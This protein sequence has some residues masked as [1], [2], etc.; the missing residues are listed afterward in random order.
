MTKLPSDDQK[1]QAFLRQ[2]RPVPPPATIDLEEQ[3]MQAIAFN[4]NTTVN[5]QTNLVCVKPQKL[6]LVRQLWLIPSTIAACLLITSS[7]H[8]FFTAPEL[9]NASLESFLETNW[10]DVTGETAANPARNNLLNDWILET[11]PVN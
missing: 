6:N 1:L 7:S 11:K 3:L 5:K 2:H 9:A 10:N 8:L 4:S